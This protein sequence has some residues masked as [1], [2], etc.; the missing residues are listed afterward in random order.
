MI[1]VTVILAPG[2]FPSSI[3]GIYLVGRTG[4]QFSL[5]PCHPDFLVCGV[6]GLIPGKS[7]VFF[8]PHL[9]ILILYMFLDFFDRKV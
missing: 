8:F 4:I 2:G 1:N 7:V 9:E 5:Y 6:F 3:G